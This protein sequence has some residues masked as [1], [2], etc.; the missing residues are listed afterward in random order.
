MYDIPELEKKWRKYKRNQIKKPLIAS[1]V[2][3][4][5]VAGVSVVAVTYLGDSSQE[6]TTKV[7]SPA[8][9]VPAKEEK[10]IVITKTS[11][12]ATKQ[13]D[14]TE[15]NP[16]ISAKSALNTTVQPSQE[17]IDLS[18]ATIVEPNLPKDDIRVLGF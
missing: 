8:K 17:S 7:A 15:K 16:L 9:T 1:I 10:A 12:T 3:L 18:K 11:A 13:A 14:A 2:T 4:V 6:E 5:L